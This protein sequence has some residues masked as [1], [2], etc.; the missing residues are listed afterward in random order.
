MWQSQLLVFSSSMVL[1]Y[2]SLGMRYFLLCEYFLN[3][4]SL[5]SFSKLDAAIVTDMQDWIDI[6]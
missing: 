1:L 3:N 2:S 6:P 4:L 5:N